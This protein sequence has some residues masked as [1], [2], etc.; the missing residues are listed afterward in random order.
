MDE[1]IFHFKSKLRA[2]PFLFVGE[3]KLDKILRFF[4]DK[5]MNSKF[6]ERNKKQL[7]DSLN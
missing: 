5:K 1:I 4:Q 3:P 2:K 6:Y 7:N